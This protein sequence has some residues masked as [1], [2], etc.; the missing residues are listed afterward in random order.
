MSKKTKTGAKV[1]AGRAEPRL[2]SNETTGFLHEVMPF[3]GMSE[4]QISAKV[5]Q[6]QGRNPS[7]KDR[8][9]QSLFTVRKDATV[10]DALDTIGH[11][12]YQAHG[13]VTTLSEDA[14]LEEATRA[15]AWGL[16]QL[17]EQAQAALSMVDNVRGMP[18]PATK[19]EP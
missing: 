1:A 6:A 9:L 10:G 14:N 3:M 18:Q 4:A 8:V 5:R 7:G 13:G 2:Q 19:V 11:L 12:L 15:K 16:V 17:L